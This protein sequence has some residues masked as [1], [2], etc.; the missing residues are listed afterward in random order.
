MEAPADL[1]EKYKDR[2]GPGVK[3]ARYAAMIEA[4]DAAMGRLFALL[5]ELKLADNTL[6]IFT[7]DNGGFSGVADN[8]PL[9]EGKG[10]LYEGGIRIPLIVRWP[11]AV[12]E[13]T[14][15]Q[16]PVISTDFYPT[17]LEAAGLSPRPGKT[18]DGESIMPLL[19]QN[20]PL[21]RKSIFFHYPNYAWHKSNRLGAVIRRGDYKLIERYDDGSV[22]LYNLAEDLSEKKDLADQMPKRAAR[23]K[24]QLDAWLKETGA[25]MPER[26]V[27]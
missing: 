14:T 13:N 24:T 11:G 6:V 8:R 10:T 23:M 19:T 5:D 7:S 9:R 21:K 26:I 20:D 12:P 27:K 2:I 25:L 18:L 1:I 16:T 22:E 17:L 4:M 3:D 15:C